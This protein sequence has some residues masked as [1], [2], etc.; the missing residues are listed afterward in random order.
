[1]HV[2]SASPL[3]SAQNLLGRVQSIV[4]GRFYPET[5]TE[6]LKKSCISIE[7]AV[8]QLGVRLDYLAFMKR[9]AES[10]EKDTF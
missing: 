7:D 9:E 8:K 3:D 5:L 4:W 6:M 2:N 10:R 1:M